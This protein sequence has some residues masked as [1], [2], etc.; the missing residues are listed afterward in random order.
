MKFQNRERPASVATSTRGTRTEPC[1]GR[2]TKA[3]SAGKRIPDGTILRCAA[4]RDAGT[5]WQIR[6]EG[7]KKGLD[8]NNFVSANQL[9][10]STRQWQNM[11]YLRRTRV[12]NEDGGNGPSEL[13]A[14]I[15][16]P[17]MRNSFMT[18]STSCDARDVLSKND[19]LF[20]NAL[21][22]GAKGW[23]LVGG[24]PCV[25]TTPEDRC[26]NHRSNFHVLGS[27]PTRFHAISDA[28]VAST[29]S[30]GEIE[31]MTQHA[32]SLK[33]V[34]RILCR[35]RERDRGWVGGWVAGKETETGKEG[36][37]Q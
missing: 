7:R 9:H 26:L 30:M 23:Q 12:N 35:E 14:R 18:L 37:R 24:L 10:W 16:K 3:T 31:R 34:G 19:W 2:N 11:N 27:R 1:T 33:L 22:A 29:N 8:K 32:A 5:A 17:L 20:P 25:S 21:V 13:G 28:A 15:H 4:Q 6:Q 36:Q